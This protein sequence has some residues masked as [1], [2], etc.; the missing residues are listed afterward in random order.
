MYEMRDGL[1][2][3]SW[4]SIKVHLPQTREKTQQESLAPHLNHAKLDV[5][6]NL[7]H[8]AKVQDS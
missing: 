6:I 4:F 1:H 7:G 2:D 3:I 8:E 5:I